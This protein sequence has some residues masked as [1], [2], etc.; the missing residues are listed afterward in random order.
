MVN[1]IVDGHTKTLNHRKIVR[2]ILKTTTYWKPKYQLYGC[3]VFTFGLQFDLC[4]LSVTLL[5][6]IY[7]VYI[8]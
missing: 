2:K 7:C 5:A 8:Q 3:P 4:P 1:L 6:M